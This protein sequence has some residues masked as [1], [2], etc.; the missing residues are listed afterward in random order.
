[1]ELA[2]L[3]LGLGKISECPAAKVL[4]GCYAPMPGLIC[5]L[6]VPVR[7]ARGTSM[8]KMKALAA[9]GGSFGRNLRL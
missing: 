3:H 9:T 7:I 4:K 6:S 5:T 8:A 1:M 2:L